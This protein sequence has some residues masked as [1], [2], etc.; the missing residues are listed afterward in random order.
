MEEEVYTEKEVASGEIQV[1][2]QEKFLLKSGQAL[3]WAVQ[4]GS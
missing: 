2:C 3:E 4:G 1:G